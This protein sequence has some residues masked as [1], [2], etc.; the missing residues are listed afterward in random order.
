MIIN[1]IKGYSWAFMRLRDA[2]WF[3]E[4]KND[5]III[6]IVIIYSNPMDLQQS[7]ACPTEHK[8]IFYFLHRSMA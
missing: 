3:V 8:Y 7:T 6:I 4:P 1:I 2:G 5:Y